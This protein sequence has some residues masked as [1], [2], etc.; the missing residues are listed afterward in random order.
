[1]KTLYENHLYSFLLDD[2]ENL[3]IFQWKEATAHMTD[4]DF[5]RAIANYAGFAFKNRGKGLLVDVT[6]FR[7]EVGEDALRWRNEVCLD[8]YLLAGANKMGY[9]MTTQ[10]LQNLA[11][12]EVKTGQFIDRYFDTYESAKEWL[13]H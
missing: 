10:S 11:M 13:L 4:D 1:M 5:I 7:H 8:R 3:L 12:D 2:E 6:K 9:I